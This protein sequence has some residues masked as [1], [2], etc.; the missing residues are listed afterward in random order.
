MRQITTQKDKERKNRT[1]QYAVGVILVLIMF[2]SVLGYSFQREEQDSTKKINYNGFNF[3]NQ[4]GFWVLEDQNFIFRYN[5]LEVEKINSQILPLSNY[6]GKPLY[7]SSEN[8][9]AGSEIYTNLNPIVQ[10]IQ[11]ACLENETCDSDL[12]IK[13]CQDN[14]IIIKEADSNKISQNENCVFIQGPYENLTKISDEFLFKIIGIRE[15]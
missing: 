6:A 2:L 14:F 5:P 15:Q 7:I 1:K 4:N 8:Q 9:E 11:Y 13:T 10:R 3:I 12:P